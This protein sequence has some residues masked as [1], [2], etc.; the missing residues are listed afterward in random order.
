MWMAS[1][2]VIRMAL[3]MR[4]TSVAARPLGGRL[5]I[6]EDTLQRANCPE[7][8]RRGRRSP[9]DAPAPHADP[10]LAPLQRSVTAA[11]GLIV[12]GRSDR[13]ELIKPESAERHQRPVS[14]KNG[15]S[16]PM[17]AMTAKGRKR[18]LKF[19]GS[20]RSNPKHRSYLHQ[21]ASG[22]LGR[23]PAT[24][25]VLAVGPLGVE[26]VRSIRIAAARGTGKLSLNIRVTCSTKHTRFAP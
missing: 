8:L 20:G 5:T 9:A 13:G 23:E 24:H 2:K 18:H 6:I 1:I 22:R 17:P 7:T 10:G 3:S 12:S 25:E 19:F 11:D 16:S 14:P 21:T 15:H 26:T 4:L